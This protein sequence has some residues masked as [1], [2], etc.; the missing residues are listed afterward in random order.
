MKKKETNYDWM[1]IP[2][3]EEELSQ[4]VDGGVF[5]PIGIVEKKLFRLDSHWGT[6]KFIFKLFTAGGV[7]FADASLE[8]VVNYAGRTR[9]LIGA[10]T[11]PVPTEID[12]TNPAENLNFSATCKSEATKNAI[13]PLGLAFGQ[14]L[15]DRLTTNTPQPKTSANGRKKPDAVMLPPDKKIQQQYNDAVETC[16]ERI[17][18]AIKTVYPEISYTGIKKLTDAQS[19]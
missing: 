2:P 10:V 7:I 4:N 19:S 17:M 15:N 1:N 16:N 9:R 8:L 12:I 18:A 3:A 13:K 6:E 11:L 14:G 5:I